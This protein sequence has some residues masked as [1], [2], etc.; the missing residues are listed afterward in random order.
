MKSYSKLIK[1]I[2]EAEQRGDHD[3]ADELR[4]QLALLQ[5]KQERGDRK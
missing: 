3:K 2:R 4:E 5:E 1:E